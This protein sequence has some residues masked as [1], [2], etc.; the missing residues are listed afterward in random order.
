MAPES[1]SPSVATLTG[2]IF[3][4]VDPCAGFS[5]VVTGGVYLQEKPGNSIAGE[6]PWR[7]SRQIFLPRNLDAAVAVD[8]SDRECGDNSEQ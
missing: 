7:H 3:G 5:G 1:Y 8:K 2:V 6:V 4:H